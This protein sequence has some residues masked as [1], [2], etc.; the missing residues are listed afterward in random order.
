[1]PVLQI[2]PSLALEIQLRGR[3]APDRVSECALNNRVREKGRPRCRGRRSKFVR[4]PRARGA[5]NPSLVFDRKDRC[6]RWAE[7]PEPN[8][9]PVKTKSNEVAGLAPPG[10]RA[11]CHT[12]LWEEKSEPP[13]KKKL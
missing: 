10:R 2:Q 12:L 9:A 13:S 7:G 3:C 5:R 8:L 11:E 6:Y 4:R 1:M